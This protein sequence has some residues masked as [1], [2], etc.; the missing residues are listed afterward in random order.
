MSSTLDYKDILKAEQR[1]GKKASRLIENS[2]RKE[3]GAKNF[4][5]GNVNR[6]ELELSKSVNTKPITGNVRLFRLSTTMARHG[7]I[8]QHGF[9]GQRSGYIGERKKS[10]KF[11][12]VTAHQFDLPSF[13]FIED[14]IEK[15]GA[16]NVLFN[17]LGA[18]RMK[19]IG[20]FF[21]GQGIKLG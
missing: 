15:S 13:P 2:I 9:S 12:R 10:G 7:F 20:I 1:I 6:R 8:L 11:Y 3:I 4:M 5:P 14:G 21:K 19:E 16:F 17:E 18:L